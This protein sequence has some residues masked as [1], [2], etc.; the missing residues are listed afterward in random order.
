MQKAGVSTVSLYQTSRIRRAGALDSKQVAVYD[1]I[2][3][4]SLS[5]DPDDFM[6]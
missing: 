5:L 6:F 3:M 1:P 4:L 2:L